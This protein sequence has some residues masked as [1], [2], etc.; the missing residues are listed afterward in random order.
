MFD[1][2]N[3]SRSGMGKENEDTRRRMTD[4]F[5]DLGDVTAIDVRLSL[6]TLLYRRAARAEVARTE[7]DLVGL[8]R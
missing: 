3:L 8:L 4:K 5:F 6:R 1:D 7:D 2:K